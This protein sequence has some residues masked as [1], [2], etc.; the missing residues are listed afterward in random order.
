MLISS[1][2]KSA[3]GSTFVQL[4][5]WVPC[6]MSVSGTSDPDPSLLLTVALTGPSSLSLLLPK[7]SLSLL[8]LNLLLFLNI[9]ISVSLC[10]LVWFSVFL[11]VSVSALV[12][13]S[14]SF[15]FPPLLL[16]LSLLT[17]I[18][19]LLSLIFGLC[20]RLVTFFLTL[21]DSI[22][23]PSDFP[24][25]LLSSHSRSLPESQF[26]SLR[27]FLMVSTALLVTSSLSSSV[28][29]LV[30][31]LFHSPIFP[32]S[33]M[34]LLGDSSFQSKGLRALIKPSC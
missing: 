8:S 5:S 32:H 10:V 4:L 11:C 1:P 18:A 13:H 6:C 26:L 15:Y 29:L 25:P 17:S 19:L 16:A 23:L 34:S 7:L 30:F 9:F 21:S 27:L 33:Q 14:V 12:S 3:S 24:C 28:C 20:V 22:S 2:C 31:P